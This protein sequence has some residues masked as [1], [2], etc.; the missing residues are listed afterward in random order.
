MGVS[1]NKR[2]NLTDRGSQGEPELEPRGLG[3][4]VT[5]N[6][7]TDVGGESHPP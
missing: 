1:P 4:Q 5:R 6:T 3:L 2:V 7:L